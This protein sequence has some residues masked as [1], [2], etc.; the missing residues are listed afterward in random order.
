MGKSG[1]ARLRARRGWAALGTWLLGVVA[2]APLAAHATLSVTPLTWNVV[3]LDSNSPAAGPQNFPIGA[4]VCSTGATSNV[5]VQLV[6]D[7]LN[8][9]INERPGSQTTLTIPS[10]AAGGCADAYFEAQVTRNAAAFDTTRRYHI[11]VSDGIDTASTP[12][13]RELYVEHLISQNR[14]SIT[15]IKV[16]GATV[17]AGGS[18]GMVVGNTYVVE[19]DGGTAT[20]GYNQ[21]EAFINLSNAVFQILSVKT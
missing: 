6:W 11:G 15:G 18:V 19:L 7:S 16:D 21:F 20:Q 9:Y 14:N 17:P 12:V 3:G 13:P 1:C 10:I 5:S 2:L 8:P 4:R